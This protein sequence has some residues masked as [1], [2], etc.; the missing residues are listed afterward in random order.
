MVASFTG[1]FRFGLLPIEVASLR[2]GLVAPTP[3]TSLD[4]GVSGKP[5]EP[6]TRRKPRGHYATLTFGVSIE[7]LPLSEL[8]RNLLLG[9]LRFRSL[10]FFETSV[11]QTVLPAPVVLFDHWP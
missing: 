2:K 8:L 11:E 5:S 4:V 7:I 9:L 1:C 10:V 3:L 6:R